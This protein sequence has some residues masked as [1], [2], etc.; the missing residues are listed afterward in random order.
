MCRRLFLHAQGALEPAHLIAEQPQGR[1]VFAQCRNEL[2]EVGRRSVD[3]E[4][5]QR[6]R[7]IGLLRGKLCERR[8]AGMH[9]DPG[10]EPA[11][12]LLAVRGMARA[13]LSLLPC[14]RHLLQTELADG[15]QHAKTPRAIEAGLDDQQVL[16]DQVC[17][18][19][20]D[21]AGRAG[22]RFVGATTI[23]AASSVAPPEKTAS[24]RKNRCSGGE[25]SS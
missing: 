22:A 21:H 11:C 6:L 9:A 18:H 10:P 7:Q 24:R 2:R 17:H 12:Q 3:I 16:V 1:P 4:P 23:A 8:L 19:V 5:M 13:R 20:D 15:L 14:G 25:S